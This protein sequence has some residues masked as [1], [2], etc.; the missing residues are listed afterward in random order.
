MG[1]IVRRRSAGGK[2]ALIGGG[3]LRGRAA[4]HLRGDVHVDR[5]WSPVHG[6]VDR[7]AHHPSGVGGSGTQCRLRDRCEQPV[8]WQ[9]LVIRHVAHVVREAVRQ[10]E[11]R[12]TIEQGV[13]DAV[14]ERGGAGSERRDTGARCVTDLRLRG[15]HEGRPRLGLCECER[16]AAEAG[17]LDQVG[18]AAASGHPE[19][20]P[21][22]RAPQRADDDIGICQP[23]A[24]IFPVGPLV[25]TAAGRRADPMFVLRRLP[26][27]VG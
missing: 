8:V 9:V 26:L 3:A 19:E 21:H 4:R 15:G 2:P 5:A 22:A 12:H 10:D 18:S 1:E 6:D 17:R 11:Q 27:L 20:A 23:C 16:Q 14:D 24:I 7:V 25:P 13:G